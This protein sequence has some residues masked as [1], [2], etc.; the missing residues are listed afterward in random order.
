MPGLPAVYMAGLEGPPIAFLH[1]VGGDHSAWRPQLLH[2]APRYRCFAWDMPGYGASPARDLAFPSLASALAELLDALEL[3]KV[4]LVGQSLGGMIAQEFAAMHPDRLHTLTLVATSPAFGRADKDWQQKFI[5]DRIGA[6]ERG[7]TM[8][9]LARDNVRRIVGPGAD[10]AGVEIAISCT[11]NVPVEA[12]KQAIRM[13]VGFDRREA[14]A[15]IAVPTLALA[16]A[17][18]TVAPAAMM[19]KMASRIPGAHFVT[20]PGAGHLINLEQP[21]AFNAA[22]GGFLAAA[23]GA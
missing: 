14:L 18:D 10:P 7:A 5:N 11:A 23:K 19:E 9:Q 21:D 6:L 3:P 4:H 1:G 22:L 20:V 15:N 2:F 13:I 16:G 8:P 12:Y 17:V